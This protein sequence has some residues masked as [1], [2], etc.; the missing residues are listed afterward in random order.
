MYE[1]NFDEWNE[2]KKTT[3]N[4]LTKEIRVGEVWFC[5]LGVNVGFETDGTG[6]NFERP[7]LVVSSF[8]V[9]GAIVVPLTTKNKKYGHHFFIG[10][11]GFVKLTQVKFLDSRRFQRLIDKVDKIQIYEIKEK[12]SNIIRFN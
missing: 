6:N 9:S 10:R 4:L 1:K 8:G 3:N 5:S 2:V 12:I 11:R 7:C